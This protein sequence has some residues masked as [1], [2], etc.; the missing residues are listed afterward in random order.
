MPKLAILTFDGFNEIDTFLAL[1]LARR[2]PTLDAFVCAPDETVRSMNGVRVAAQAS[3]AALSTAD[4]V[5]VGS[6]AETQRVVDDPWLME[7][8]TLDPS[9]QLVTAQCSGALVLERLGLLRGRPA[10]TDTKTRAALEARGVTVLDQAFEAHA[11]VAT[12]GG[13]LAS[14]YL[15]TFLVTRLVS[16]EAAEAALRYVAPIGEQDE[17][18]ARAF[19]VVGPY[20][21]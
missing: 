14:V 3:L 10:C 17:T 1:N 12:A 13:C 15:T 11:N 7:R 6:G 4:A 19:R 16:R 21:A 8:I 5:L 20:V 18:V 2:A 9:R